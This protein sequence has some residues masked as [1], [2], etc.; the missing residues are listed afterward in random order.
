M[1]MDINKDLLEL[2]EGN[3]QKKNVFLYLVMP[4]SWNSKIN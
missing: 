2:L 1:A 4:C 3:P